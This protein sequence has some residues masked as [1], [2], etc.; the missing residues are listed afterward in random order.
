MST[1]R[2]CKFSSTNVCRLSHMRLHSKSTVDYHYSVL[3]RIPRNCSGLLFPLSPDITRMRLLLSAT[4][5]RKA[6]NG[7]I[8][9]TKE[10]LPQLLVPLK[11]KKEVGRVIEHD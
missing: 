6:R 7:P 11:I 5:L 1:P 8:G 3:T 9:K 2:K 4:N 10:A